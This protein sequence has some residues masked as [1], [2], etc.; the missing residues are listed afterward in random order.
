M[1]F[2]FFSLFLEDVRSN[3]GFLDK[4]DGIIVPGRKTRLNPFAFFFHSLST[5]K[6]KGRK[7]R[8]LLYIFPM[9]ICQRSFLLLAK[10]AEVIASFP[11][12]GCKDKRF[13][14]NIPNFF[15]IFFV[16]IQLSYLFKYQIREFC[17]L[18]IAK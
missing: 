4:I 16:I 2:F 6:K 12:C 8:C 11:F 7:E 9:S 1:L 3:L 17:T 14:C 18:H 5:P 10:R 15:I 13:L